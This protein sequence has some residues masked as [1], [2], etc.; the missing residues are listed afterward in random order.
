MSIPAREMPR[1]PEDITA[2][3]IE[4]VLRDAGYAGSRLSR[5]DAT[6]VGAAEGMTSTVARVTLDFI[7]P[8]GAP[9]SLIVK[10]P[11]PEARR[12]AMRTLGTYAREVRF[13][14]DIAASSRISVPHCYLA[15]HEPDSDDF[16]IVMEDLS[17]F[18]LGNVV[19]GCSVAEARALVL[20]L[21]GLHAAWWQ[22]PALEGL[23][24][25]PPPTL[26]RLASMAVANAET[27]VQRFGHVLPEAVRN[28]IPSIGEFALA[29]EGLL[30]DGPLTLCNGDP[31]LDNVA[32]TGQRERPLVIFD[33]GTCLRANPA[34][35]LA[36]F[37]GDSLEPEVR[38]NV[39]LDLLSA[40]RAALLAR[41]IESYSLDQ[42]WL[43]YRRQYL[44]HMLRMVA[45]A[46]GHAVNAAMFPLFEARLR[47]RCRALVDLDV[48]A[49]F[50]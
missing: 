36:Y 47:R 23:G 17:E 11:G 9:P 15:W 38:A 45:V 3:W 48:L 22:S 39:E 7:S 12:D 50:D 26:G 18:R 1:R 4:A 16:A 44:A 24:W 37:L 14:S 10:L 13:Y 41:R 5:C 40:Y 32:F 6:V 19:D 21:A 30:L 43:G 46:G 33:W 8:G 49:A 31:K 34:Y 25:L 28:A 20:E 35:D 2:S 27:F 42:L 29:H